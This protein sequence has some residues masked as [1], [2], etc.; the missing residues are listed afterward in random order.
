[1]CNRQAEM[2]KRGLFEWNEWTSMLTAQ[3]ALAQKFGDPDLGDTCYKHWL[4][5][6]EKL[7]STKELS[8]D[9]ELAQCR[10][11]WARAAQR[12]PHGQSIDLQTRRLR[13]RLR[14][15]VLADQGKS[16]S[17][18]QVNSSLLFAKCA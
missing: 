18:R 1:M 7:V 14:S 12:T 2:L 9:Q 13:G 3:I 16:S 4:A 5:A 11:A 15:S 10:N 6:F 17:K 8:S